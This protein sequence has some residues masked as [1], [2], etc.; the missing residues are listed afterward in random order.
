[1]HVPNNISSFNY[2]SDHLYKYMHNTC[3]I[4]NLGFLIKANKSFLPHKE[5][6][7]ILTLMLQLS[8]YIRK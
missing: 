5:K 1:M 7:I 8:Q 6:C 2:F 3:I 4:A